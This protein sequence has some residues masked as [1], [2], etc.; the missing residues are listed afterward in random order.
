MFTYPTT[1]GLVLGVAETAKIENILKLL[2][3]SFF[4]KI[5]KPDNSFSVSNGIEIS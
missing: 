3:S 4:I 1:Y 5:F 2:E